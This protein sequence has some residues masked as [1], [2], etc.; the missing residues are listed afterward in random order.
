MVLVLSILLG[1]TLAQAEAPEGQELIGTPAPEWDLIHW[2]NAP[3]SSLASLKGRVVLVRWWTA[4]HC[5]F[6]AES[7]PALNELNRLYRQGG[8]TV[9]GIYHHKSPAP[10]DPEQVESFAR[11]F[12]FQFPVAIDPG[13]QTLKRWWLASLDRRWTSVSFLIDRQG[14]IQ[15]IHPGGS[16]AIGSPEYEELK[17]QVEA[18]L[19]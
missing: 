9:I 7:A 11:D 2:T 6:C 5:T 14:I 17:T 18:L 3:P 13:W 1:A 10:L 8:L 16:Y 12:G 4:P 15:Y 19:D